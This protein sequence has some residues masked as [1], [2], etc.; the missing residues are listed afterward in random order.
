LVPLLAELPELRG[1]AAAPAPRLE[2]ARTR[3]ALAAAGIA[4]PELDEAYLE[5]IARRIR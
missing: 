3:A 5:R 1:A 2:D 4:C